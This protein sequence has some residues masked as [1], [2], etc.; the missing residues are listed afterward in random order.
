MDANEFNL[1]S[2]WI[3]FEEKRL[4]KKNRNMIVDL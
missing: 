3:E 2:E 1:L 4:V